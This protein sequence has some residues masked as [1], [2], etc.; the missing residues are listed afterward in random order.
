MS[1]LTTLLSVPVIV[2]NINLCDITYPN[3]LEQAIELKDA[4][5]DNAR[6]LIASTLS[7]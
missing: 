5:I 3:P 1:K 7:T 6:I 4:F 2:M